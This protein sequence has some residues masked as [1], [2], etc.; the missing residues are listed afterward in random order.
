M[1]KLE[2]KNL[3]WNVNN[4]D[5]HYLLQIGICGRTGSGKSSLTM[6][7][8]RAVHISDGEIL[9]DDINIMHVPLHL[10]RS[11]ISIIP[12]EPVMFSGTIRLTQLLLV[13]Q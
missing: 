1:V 4:Y 5:R 7:L 11:K 8:F 3:L 12:Q 13:L 10:L 6:S 2:P 9:V